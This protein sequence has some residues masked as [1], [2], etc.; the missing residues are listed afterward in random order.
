MESAEAFS[1]LITQFP[2]IVGA[3]RLLLVAVSAQPLYGR[4]GLDESGR[5]LPHSKTQARC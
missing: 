1:T 4:A 3:T 2:A 5:G